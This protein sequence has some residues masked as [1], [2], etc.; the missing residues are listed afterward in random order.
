M[1]PI[2]M[3][4]VKCY[5]VQISY[6]EKNSIFHTCTKNAYGYSAFRGH[7]TIFVGTV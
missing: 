5:F 6:L 7:N 4:G 1:R 3:L 2:L